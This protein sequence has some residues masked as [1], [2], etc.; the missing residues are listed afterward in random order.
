MTLLSILQI[1][2]W[3]VWCF[4]ESFQIP[5]FFHFGQYGISQL[6]TSKYRTVV[7]QS[8]SYNS[9]CTKF[10]R[11]RVLW[12]SSPIFLVVHLQSTSWFPDTEQIKIWYSVG[13]LKW[14]IFFPEVTR[15]ILLNLIGSK[16]NLSQ[17]HWIAGFG[18]KQKPL[19]R[20][21]LLLKIQ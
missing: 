1:T 16:F 2:R 9:L 6:S 19:V 18:C 3:P 8:K 12:I 11:A 17:R 20:W 14:R 5:T 7:Q 15:R 13:E 4:V 10:K 21:F